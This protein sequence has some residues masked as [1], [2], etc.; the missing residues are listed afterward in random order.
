MP[1]AAAVVRTIFLNKLHDTG[2]KTHGTAENRGEF[3]RSWSPNAFFHIKK[4]FIVYFIIFFGF[5]FIFKFV[6]NV[7]KKK[8]RNCNENLTKILKRKLA[9]VKRRRKVKK[10]EKN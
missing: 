4:F 9:R 2:R 1:P 3:V 6:K 10:K 8:V 5:N 7:T